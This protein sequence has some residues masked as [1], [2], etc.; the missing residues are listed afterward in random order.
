MKKNLSFTIYKEVEVDET[1]TSKDEK[2]NTIQITKKVKK[3]EPRKFFIIKPGR[4][5]VEDSELFFSSIYWRCVKDYNIQPSMQLQ[6]RL[7]DDGGVLSIE[8]K[9]E[10]NDLNVKLFEKQA[11]YQKLN[12]KSDKTE[13]E[14]IDVQKLLDETV[15]IF[16][17]IQLF[18]NKMGS[19]LYQNTAENIARNRTATWWM[20]HL[21]YEE[22]SDGKTKLVFGD[23]SYQDKLKIYDQIEENEDLFEIEM[24]KKLLLATSLWYFQKVQNQEE[25]DVMLEAY[26]QSEIIDAV[27][28]IDENLKK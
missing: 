17:N 8:Q 1:E 4:S 2:G 24:V 14:K 7:L 23:G 18:E 13:Q 20:L 22:L 9:K 6:K 3:K 5:L 25:F 26:N 19:L 27:S 11:E 21:S 12:S 28:N 10:Y 15:E 16:N